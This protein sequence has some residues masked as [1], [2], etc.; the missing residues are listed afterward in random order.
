MKGNIVD[1]YTTSVSGIDNNKASYFWCVFDMNRLICGKSYC[2]LYK[3]N[4]I[5]PISWNSVVCILILSWKFWR[6]T[7]KIPVNWTGVASVAP[8]VPQLDTLSACLQGCELTDM[9]NTWTRV[10]PGTNN[11]QWDHVLDMIIFLIDMVAKINY[12]YMRVKMKCQN[13]TYDDL[14]MISRGIGLR[15][16]HFISCCRIQPSSKSETC[17]SLKRG[18]IWRYAI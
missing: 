13:F 18:P 7:F 4:K 1:R 15:N 11:N 8:I 6:Y 9:L 5:L 3:W 17:A 16:R 12:R 2:Y 10:R 14:H